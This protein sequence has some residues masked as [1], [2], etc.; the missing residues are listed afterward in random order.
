MIVERTLHVGE[1]L[2]ILTNQDIF[3]SIS[4][5][6][7]TFDHLKVD[8]LT[9]IWLK[10]TVN[11]QLIGVVKF[12]QTFNRCYD[13]HIHILPDFRKKHSKEAATKILDWC[14][15]FIPGSTLYA[16]V[17]ELCQNVKNFLLRNDFEETG[18]I[19]NAWLKDG[20]LRNM[21]ILSRGV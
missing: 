11:D 16:T 4:E 19:P 8:V 15:E 1:C 18:V 10:I 5:D 9:D 13:S 17:P 2:L 14:H 12:K 7:A 21:F 6:G 3:D 20:K